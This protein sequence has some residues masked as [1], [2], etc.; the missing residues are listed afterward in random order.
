MRTILIALL[1]IVFFILSIPLFL[2][3]LIIGVFSIRARTILAQKVIS[4]MCRAVLWL[5]GV[6]VT[7]MGM[8]NVPKNEAVVYVFNHRSYFDI[9]IS[10]ATV[11]NLAGFISMEKMKKVP[12]INVWMIFL[13]CLFIERGNTREG[14][15]TIN[16]GIELLKKGHSIFIAP[17]G[18]RNFKGDIDMLPFK[19]GSLRLA[20]RT[21]CAIIPVAINNADKIYEAQAPWI[22]KTN[23]VIEYGK[24]VYINDLEGDNR[25]F[26]GAYVQR[27]I[28]EMLKKNQNIL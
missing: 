9:V 8:E 15:K 5:G 26:A 19:E 21:G 22:K 11:P 16:A 14:L 24:P 28:Y 10:Y 27:I 20:K 3:E 4:V 23:V 17:E 6:K 12:F 7:A 18:K 2:L 25:K 1:F 13:Q